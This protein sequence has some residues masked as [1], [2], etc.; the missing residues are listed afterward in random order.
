MMFKKRM[1]L[2]LALGILS[3]FLLTSASA[4]DSGIESQEEY[5]ISSGR[6]ALWNALFE[7]NP[8]PL[9][10]A[11]KKAFFEQ[12]AVE[13][14]QVQYV[15]DARVTGSFSIYPDGS[16]YVD[17]QTS[18]SYDGQPEIQQTTGNGNIENVYR[19]SSW[20]Y[21]LQPG[22]VSWVSQ[23]DEF[24]LQN[25]MLFEVPGAT[26]RSPG[27]LKYELQSIAELY[28]LNP[29]QPVP[30]S[31]ITAFDSSP[32]WAGQT[33]GNALSETRESRFENSDKSLATV[34]QEHSPGIHDYQK[35]LYTWWE[36]ANQVIY[37]TRPIGLTDLNG[38]GNRELLFLELD[39]DIGY[40]NLSIWSADDGAPRSLFF[41][42]GA[43]LS[44][45]YSTTGLEMY[46]LRD[47]D[48]V[49]EFETD[50]GWGIIRMTADFSGITI[51]DK[52]LRDDDGLQGKTVPCTRNGQEISVET[53]KSILATWQQEKAGTICAFP[54]R[55][56]DCIGFGYT[57]EDAMNQLQ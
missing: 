19:L 57:W 5:W 26:E 1:T 42:R 28:H 32:L 20:I 23:D 44:D 14:T 55:E 47:G 52:L 3:L 15:P 9:S 30:F 34:L 27:V 50:M 37:P 56:K 53:Y 41:M 43:T 38:D 11:E 10:I 46:F 49:I 54:W 21:A 39:A 12:Y 18:F 45:D 24:V 17:Y 31:F 2:L 51:K 40:G 35:L 4:D 48:I 29:E 22:T 13:M 36:G 7:S 8:P 33:T 6:E 16:F 25:Y